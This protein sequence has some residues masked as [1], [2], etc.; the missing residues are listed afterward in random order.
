MILDQITKM[1]KRKIIIYNQLQTNYKI[2]K[3]YSV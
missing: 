2:T 3:N 1:F